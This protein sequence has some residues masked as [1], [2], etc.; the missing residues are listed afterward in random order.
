MAKRITLEVLL[1]LVIT[2]GIAWIGLAIVS[3]FDSGDPVAAFFDGAPR[4]LFGLMGIGLVLWTILLVI[5]SIVNR[6]RRAGRR[7]ATHLVSL[8]VSIVVT[9]L[10]FVALAFADSGGWGMLLVGITVVAGLILGVAG[11][12]AVF[13]VEL[14]IVRDTASIEA[15]VDPV[16][17][18]G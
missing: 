3:L 6:H 2:I 12:T 17:L 11:T 1:I 13:I 8:T 4:I 18:D 5:G 10:I 9:V 15:P 16:V 7:I 14:R